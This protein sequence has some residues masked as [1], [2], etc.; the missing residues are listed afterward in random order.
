M[1][2]WLVVFERL[3][4]LTC[5]F[6]S[7]ALTPTGAAGA[8]QDSVA[9]AAYTRALEL[10]RR[11]D[12]NGALTLLWEA[13]GHAPH[14]AEIQNSLGEALERIGALDGAVA[15]FRAAV[16]ARPEFQKASN[17]LILALAKAGKGEEAVARAKALAK[18]EP[19]DPD[20]Q[21]TLALAQS[22]QD[23]MAA[24]ETF[25]RT[26]TLAPRH[27]LAHY[28]LALALSRIDRAADAID[29]LHRAIDI[30]PRPELNYALGVVYWHQ[31]DLDKAAAALRD[32]LH[33]ND[34]YADAYYTLG[35]V[36]KAKRDWKGAT[37]SLT[38][39]V[40]VRPDW[41]EAHGT[42]AQVLRLAG[43]DGRADREFARA[44]ELRRRAA[45][46]QEASVL[47]AAGTE[48]LDRGEAEPALGLFRKAT[49][50]LNSY[51]P[52]FYQMGRALDR[53]GD[54][55]GARSAFVRAHELNPSLTPPAKHP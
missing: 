23:V 28:N 13:A 42:L 36:L 14:D 43:E 25:R 12:E 41:A 2:Q 11:G 10:Q 22:E 51:A 31:G 3:P 46:E 15:A 21:F 35:V 20:R 40:A 9:T 52:A 32:A 26:L 37:D 17:N 29:E 6:V 16:A 34:R 19:N 39:A 55:A 1:A 33:A 53:L 24:I 18:S 49:S 45:L 48:K 8:G 4:L 27:V 30:D 47:T 54:H 50:V 5:L 38:R 44:D 7:L